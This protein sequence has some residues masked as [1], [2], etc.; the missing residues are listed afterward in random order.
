MANQRCY[1][2]L[3]IGGRSLSDHA[4]S[5]VAMRTSAENLRLLFIYN[6]RVTLYAEQPTLRCSSENADMDLPTLRPHPHASNDH[7][8]FRWEELPVPES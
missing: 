3:H 1:R 4:T 6:R 5:K 7:A 2:L 8:L